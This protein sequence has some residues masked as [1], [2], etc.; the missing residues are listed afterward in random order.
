MTDSQSRYRTEEDDDE[1]I[2]M[3]HVNSRQSAVNS[4]YPM[5]GYNRTT[6]VLGGLLCILM[7]IGLL[8][9]VSWIWSGSIQNHNNHFIHQLDQRLSSGH[10]SDFTT[11]G[12]YSLTNTFK[13]GETNVLS[14]C[15]LALYSKNGEMLQPKNTDSN[16]KS[17]PTTTTTDPFYII[18][19][20]FNI[21]YNANFYNNDIY[22]KLNID[23]SERYLLI[24]YEL[25][26]NFDQFSSIKLIES[27]INLRTKSLQLKK[28]FI[29]CSNN[30]SIEVKRCQLQNDGI[31]LMNNTRLLYMDNPS[32]Y[33]ENNDKPINDI[34]LEKNDSHHIKDHSGID[35]TPGYRENLR[36]LKDDISHLRLYHLLFY[37]TDSSGRD[38]IFNENIIL[39]ISLNKC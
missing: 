2:R 10:H 20:Y 31:L 38:S 17:D 25:A 12:L 30:P 4:S 6:Y 16:Y 29:V 7:T 35:I 24:H 37:K 28:E 26:S 34:P 3:N 39:S 36:D 27:E 18:K 22:K 5:T 13:T 11:N 1:T 19:S 15:H 21:K 9:V 14:L 8:F 33:N 32:H 23:P